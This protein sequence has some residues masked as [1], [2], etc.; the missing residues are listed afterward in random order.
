MD[1]SK[2]YTKSKN[3]VTREI[4]GEVILVPVVSE[5]PE[6]DSIYVLNETSAFIWKLLN[7]ENSL[8]NILNMMLERYEVT[9]EKAKKDIVEFIDTLLNFGAIEEGE[10]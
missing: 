1:G 10:D 5:A 3:I 8:D 6:M 9:P 7:G 2:I 4:E